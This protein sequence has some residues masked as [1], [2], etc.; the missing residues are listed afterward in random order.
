MLVGD[1]LG[2]TVGPV[3]I[4]DDC[5]SLP[6]ATPSMSFLG[7]IATAGP[8]YASNG[9]NAAEAWPSVISTVASSTARTPLTMDRSALRG[10][11]VRN[12]STDATTLPAVTGLP[13]WNFTPLRR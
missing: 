6:A 9:T 4:T 3:P 13:S 5:G 1:P 12:R 10:D 8:G 2:E 11:S 7:M